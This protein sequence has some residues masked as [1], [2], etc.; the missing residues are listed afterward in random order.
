MAFAQLTILR[1]A[2]V[3][4]PAG[5]DLLAPLTENKEGSIGL[6]LLPIMHAPSRT[7]TSIPVDST[8]LY[9]VCVV[10]RTKDTINWQNGSYW[11]AWR[12]RQTHCQVPTLLTLLVT[13]GDAYLGRVESVSPMQFTKS[14]IQESRALRP[15]ATLSDLYMLFSL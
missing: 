6:I 14:R 7:S 2:Q 1:A 15:C 9:Q 13:W 5:R 3:T 10:R 11:H 8:P 4:L 12:H